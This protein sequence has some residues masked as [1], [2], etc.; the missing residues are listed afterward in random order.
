MSDIIERLEKATGPDQD[1]DEDI[2]DMAWPV[3]S[4]NGLTWRERGQ[5]MLTS[6]AI[7]PRY[8][9]S[10]DAAMTLKP[11]GLGI[12]LRHSLRDGERLTA[13]VHLTRIV[14]QV[15]GVNASYSGEHDFA[16]GHAPTIPLA[17]CIAALKAR[18]Q[19]E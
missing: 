18:E 4:R 9:A 15:L 13:E 3:K 5:Q 14:S 7:T 17:L 8:T 12:Y 19:S 10:I 6:D 16:E 1:L 2:F 11:N